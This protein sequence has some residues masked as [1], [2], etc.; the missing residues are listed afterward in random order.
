MLFVSGGHRKGKQK[1]GGTNII[2]AL[3]GGLNDIFQPVNGMQPD[4]SKL[5]V[6]ITDGQDSNPISD[7]ESVAADYNRRNIRL[8]VIGV[9]SV[10]EN[11]LRKLVQNENEDLFISGR[12][13]D[14]LKTFVKGV[15]QTICTGK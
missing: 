3:Q 12:F 4:S 6:L 2:K 15:G 14:L 7:Y 9:G 13:E 1:G 5:A 10:S 11:K 8:I